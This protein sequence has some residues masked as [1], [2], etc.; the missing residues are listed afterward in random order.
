MTR[1]RKG[2]LIAGLILLAGFTYIAA[3][4]GHPLFVVNAYELETA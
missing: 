2:A 4:A 1:T 3:A